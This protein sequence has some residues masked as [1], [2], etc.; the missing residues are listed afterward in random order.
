MYDAEV[1]GFNYRMGEL[2]AA[3]GVEQMK[4]L[5]YFLMKRKKLQ[6]FRVRA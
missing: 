2:H 5:P 1:L 3:I 6:S 4:K